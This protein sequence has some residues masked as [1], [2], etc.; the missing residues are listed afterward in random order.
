[1]TETGA[2]MRRICLLLGLWL[3]LCACCSGETL[4]HEDFEEK[5]PVFLWAHSGEQQINFKG[6]TDEK[7]FS[8]EKSFKLDVTIKSGGWHYWGVQMKVPCAGDLKFSAR[9]L[10]EVAENIG[11]SAR[12]LGAVGLGANFVSAPFD[13]S[14]CLAFDRLVQPSDEWRLQQ[15]DLVAMGAD[16]AESVVPRGV[17]GGTGENVVVYLDKWYVLTYAQTGARLVIYVDDVRIEG[18]VP[19][20]ADH[21]AEGKRRWAPV[22]EAFSRR[23]SAWRQAIKTA[24]GEMARVEH[25]PPLAQRIKEAAL[26]SVEAVK[27]ALAKSEEEGSASPSQVDKVESQLRLLRFATPNLKQVAA[28]EEAARPLITYVTQPIA[29]ARILPDALVVPGHVADTIDVA[30]C[31]GEYESATFTVYALRDISRLRVRIADLSG[32]ESTI[33]AS[34]AEVYAVKCWY[35]AG[36]SVGGVRQ[37]LLVPELLLKDDDL[38]RTDPEKKGNYLRTITASGEEEYVLISAQ[39]GE[40]LKDIQPRDADTLQPVNIPAGSAK[41][42]WISLHVPENAAAGDYQGSITLTG[43]DL[44]PV[45]W[46]LRLRVLPFKLEKSPLRYCIYYRGELTK[47]GRGSI[48]SEEKSPQQYLAEMRDLKAHG[49]E[50]PTVYQGYDE[51]LLRKMFD[52]RKEADLSTGPLYTLGLYTGNSTE[53]AALEALKE[54]VEKW[55][56]IAKEYGYDEVYGYGIDEAKGEML[57]SQRAAWAAVREAGGKVFVA[58]SEDVFEAMGDLL[59]LAVY[60]GPPKAEQAAKFHRVGHQIFCYANPFVREE[61]PETYRRNYGLLLWKAGY[62]GTMNYAYQH[63]FGNIWNDFDARDSVFAYPTVKGVIGTIQWEGFREGVDDVR[64]LAALLKA[65]ERAKSDQSKA[66]LVREAERWGED[67]DVAADLDALRATMVKWILGLM[68]VHDGGQ[69]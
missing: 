54:R 48:S 22:R 10:L 34:A 56:A 7:A 57:R 58:C 5:D 9:I 13:T 64:Y 27:D 49:V 45:E 61:E 36:A 59:D 21:E 44:S 31:A 41:Q 30:A 62:D 66:T 16:I 23:F 33:P 37:R 43:D 29:N 35:Q 6:V 2:T 51:E 24:E 8:G 46:E 52:L 28:V 47:N 12:S 19:R 50:Y 65:I 15:C 17:F 63:S 68:Q 60:H 1:M 55:L 67:M 20:T 32:A 4:Y 26:E 3:V 11:A 25:L 69:R 39:E 14:G 53:A 38:V 40:D 18:K 42:F